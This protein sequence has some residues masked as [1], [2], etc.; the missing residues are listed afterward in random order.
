MA[1]RV[2]RLL[3]Q[4]VEG[5]LTQPASLPRHCTVERG[6]QLLL[7]LQRWHYRGALS[8]TL[9]YTSTTTTR[10][11]WMACQCLHSQSSSQH[12]QHCRCCR[13][14]HPHPSCTLSPRSPHHHH[15]QQQDLSWQQGKLVEL[16]DAL[17]D[18]DPVSGDASALTHLNLT[19]NQLL[20][21]PLTLGLATRLVTL[22]CGHNQLRALPDCVGLLVN[23]EVLAI[24]CNQ[25][26]VLPG[27]W[28]LALCIAAN[29]SAQSTLFCSR[30]TLSCCR[31][32]CT[33]DQAQATQRRPEPTRSAA[34]VFG[35]HTL[36][37]TIGCRQQPRFSH[38]TLVRQRINCAW[39]RC[40]S[41]TTSSQRCLM[42]SHCLW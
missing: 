18:R 34:Q 16:P 3:L 22:H 25:L 40:R 41:H 6:T 15:H 7:Q 11:L 2:V 1:T 4:P 5:S 17:F 36:Y 37:D 23:L 21:L 24:E 39:R 38:L 33:L 13:H 10:L 9:S 20:G 28:R 42:S 19:N 29:V 12:C 8:L 32:H 31:V 27:A 35:M 26:T 30:P 14:Y